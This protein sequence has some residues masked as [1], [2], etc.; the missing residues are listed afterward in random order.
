MKRNL[1]LDLLKIIACFSVIILHVSGIIATKNNN[2]T[3][4]HI[5]YYMA[6]LAVPVFFMVNGNLLLNKS[7]INYNYVFRKI[8]NII[9]VV[10]SWNM[11]IFFGKL[12]IN[13]K[14]TNPF[15]NTASNLIQKGYFWQFWF[16]GSLIIIYLLLPMLYKYFKNIKS[17]II[18]TVILIIISLAIDLLSIIRSVHGSS[19]IQVHVI[20]TFRLWTWFAYYLL[21]GLLGKKEIKEYIIRHINISLNW[22]IFIISLI[23]ISIY[24]FN[25]RF[26]YNN[27]HAEFFY[28]NILTFI[29]ILSLFILIYRQNFEKYKSKIVNLLSNNIMGIYIIHVTI[30]KIFTHFNKFD[31]TILN[32]CLIF[33]VSICSSI[34]VIIISKLPLV[35]KL[36]KI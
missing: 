5:L 31:T 34:I 10:F 14:I 22:T 21:G 20:Q 8:V 11:L 2:Y 25:M 23:T 35:N 27:S 30:I 4:N 6:G 16:F 3:I 13:K 36:V 1:G 15:V 17:A 18:I 24:Q 32:I 7:N 19:I 28:D 29:Y 9:L 26:I 12:I 33:L